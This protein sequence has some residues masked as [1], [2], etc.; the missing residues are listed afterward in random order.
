M[1]RDKQLIKAAL[2]LAAE[3]CEKSAYA[4]DA[5]GHHF[6]YSIRAIDPADVLAGLPPAPD[7]VAR[8]GEAMKHLHDIINCGNCAGSRHS[9]RLALAALT[10]TPQPTPDAVAQLVEAAEFFDRRRER[11]ED[12]VSSGHSRRVPWASSWMLE[13]DREFLLD[14]RNAFDALSITLAAFKGGAR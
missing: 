1:T 11:I 3:T 6:A 5:D 14:L 8:L 10:V 13:D 7:A 9:A 4:A 2:E 12:D